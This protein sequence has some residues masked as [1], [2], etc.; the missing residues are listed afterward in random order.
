MILDNPF[1]L[2]ILLNLCT[3]VVILFDK[4]LNNITAKLINNGMQKYK[5]FMT[6]IYLKEE[7]EEKVVVKE[8]I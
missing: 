2:L 6:N 3:F 8:K 5:Y 1:I 7:K 4:V